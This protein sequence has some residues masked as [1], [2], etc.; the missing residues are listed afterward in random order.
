MTRRARA[1]SALAFFSFAVPGGSAPPMPGVGYPGRTCS[2]N[3]RE[4]RARAASLAGGA[5]APLPQAFLPSSP[6]VLV[7]RVDFSDK[8]MAQTLAATQGIF[9]DFKAYWKENAFG[10]FAPEPTVTSRTSGGAAGAN[11][12]YRLGA[13]AAYGA[14][15]GSDVACN[16]PRLFD[17]AAAAA[18]AD[19]A[20]AQ[21]D[22]LM[23]LHAG[24]GQESTGSGSDIW[25][26]YLGADRSAG[27]R[28][29]P[30]FTVV[31]ESEAVPPTT[32]LPVAAHEY[33]HQL[34]LPDLYNTDTGNSTMGRWS[35]MDNPYTTIPPHLDAWSKLWL[36]FASA[37]VTSGALTLGPIELDAG[38]VLK[39]P[40]RTGA[41]DEFFLVEYR[42]RTSGAAFDTQ[43]PMDGLAVY[44]VDGRL[45]SG[46]DFLDANTVNAPVANGRGHFGVDLV[47][48]DGVFDGAI[49]TGDAYSN[50]GSFAPPASNGFDGTASGV[51]VTAVT[52]VG[53]SQ[54]SLTAADPA[55]SSMARAYGYPTPFSYK[56]GRASKITF[57]NLTSSARVRVFS[58]GGHLIRELA[59]DASG[60]AEW[61]VLDQGGSRLGAGTYM[62]VFEGDGSRRRQLIMV[63]P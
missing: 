40:V 42:F 37:R 20:L 3:A 43:L 55:A 19:Y 1:L 39:L 22:H 52:G 59:A 48:A 33:G 61:D 14:D 13:L 17:D 47:Q 56:A 49:G 46:M 16:H 10:A 11:G 54:A 45:A 29:F 26:A 41:A 63:L 44:H 32:P 57:I 9:S 53:T 6:K 60:T 5:R 21:F 12:A 4:H 8:A 38:A 7:I 36:G 50:G 58:P 2:V 35:L 27:G 24:D 34:G 62:A 31:P 23:V 30:G 51:S 18:G 28:T 15:C 25:S